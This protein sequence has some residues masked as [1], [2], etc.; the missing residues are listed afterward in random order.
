[1]IPNKILNHLLLLTAMS[2]SEAIIN[3]WEIPAIKNLMSFVVFKQRSKNIK[4]KQ[5]LIND[6]IYFLDFSTLQN[7]FLMNFAIYPYS[8]NNKSDR[9]TPKHL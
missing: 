6:I 9:P 7:I 1:M 2:H 3:N 5:Y 4:V 8:P